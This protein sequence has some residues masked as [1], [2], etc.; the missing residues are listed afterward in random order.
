MNNKKTKTIR[1]SALL[2][3]FALIG[4]LL[5]FPE[6]ATPE[7]GHAAATPKFIAGSSAPSLSTIYMKKGSTTTVRGYFLEAGER[8]K[9]YKSSKTS[10]VSVNSNGKLKAKKPGKATITLTTNY[11]DTD[12]IKVVVVK[13]AKL[14][15]SIQISAAKT[16]NVMQTV[17]PTVKV[18]PSGTTSTVKWFSYDTSIATVNAAGYIKGKRAGTVRIRAITSNGKRSYCM[19]TVRD[20]V[21]ISKKSATVRIDRP[22]TLVLT[23]TAQS[24]AIEWSSSDESVAIVQGGAIFPQQLGT[25][26]ITATASKSGTTATCRL[27]VVPHVPSKG[28]RLSP[29]EDTILATKSM[30][31]KAILESAVDG[32]ESNDDISW[33]SSNLSVASVTQEGVVTGLGY[34]TA[35]I[36]ALTE[37]GF[38]AT[39]TI[40]VSTVV[41]KLGRIILTPGMVYKPAFSFYGLGTSDNVTYTSSDTSIA[42][43]STSG[44]VYANLR[45]KSTGL[46]KSGTV[47]ITA[48]TAAGDSD[49]MK[50]TVNDEP[51]IVDVSKWQGD[52]D[53][54]TASQSIDLAILRV[55]HGADTSKE[56]K[57]KSYA[58]DC[59]R[60]GVP[61]GVYAYV[62]YKTKSAAESQ[63]KKFF[64]Q[65]VSGGRAPLFFV[66][67][68]EES[69]ITRANTEAYIA[70]LRELAKEKG[71]TRLKVGVYIGHHLYSKLN[72]N[73]STSKSSAKTPDFV[74]IP[75]YNSNIGA[76]TTSMDI[77]D[78]PCDMWQ[79]SSTGRIPGINGNVDMNTLTDPAGDWL[80]DKPTFSFDWL[81]AGSEAG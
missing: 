17:R 41:S 12:T 32:A 29:D 56:P 11:G 71:I 52:I 35:V 67:D 45:D 76:R 79:Y 81:I 54:A 25:A 38:Q 14:A 13:K 30:K 18:S 60:Y 69:Y 8:V 57:Y 42:R 36:T 9:K 4:A 61:F 39:A 51:T 77:P 2:L 68:A 75:R 24:G 73:L 15:K 3:A 58:N 20:A 16:V 63:A 48:T 33:S 28:I 31:I 70:K 37:S 19:V 34:G 46:A 64:N 65:A 62:T 43:V 80:T 22:G 47:T 50:V 40:T 74:W 55:L 1:Y 6:F 23:A 59:K 49:T 5:V 72:L 26:V 44:T 10:V 78:F 27:T 53:W 21:T 66:V 7:Q